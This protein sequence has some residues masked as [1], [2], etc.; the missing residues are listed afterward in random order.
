LGKRS[1]FHRESG[2]RAVVRDRVLAA[3][4]PDRIGL[5]GLDR[6]AHRDREVIE[7]FGMGE[8][9]PQ[10]DVLGQSELGGGDQQ[11]RGGRDFQST[12]QSHDNLLC[13]R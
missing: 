3:L 1:V 6:P 10:E 8:D 11:G 7:A 13:F 9:V 5:D 2:G 4:S 12:L